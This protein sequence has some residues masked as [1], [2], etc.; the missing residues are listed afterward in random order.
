MKLSTR[1]IF[2]TILFLLFT[3]AVLLLTPLQPRHRPATLSAFTQAL[4]EQKLKAGE[5]TAHAFSNAWYKNSLIYTAEVKMFFDSDGDGTG[6]LRGMTSK[7]DYI[8]SLGTDIIWLPPVQPSPLM[9]DGYDISDF[10]AVDPRL[11]TMADFRELV[12]EAKKR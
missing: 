4:A 11:G 7:L 6:D 1:S 10:F 5:D 9:D 3:V 12:N 2:L 8:K